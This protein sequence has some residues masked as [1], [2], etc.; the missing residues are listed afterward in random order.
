ML[1]TGIIRNVAALAGLAIAMLVNGQE[2]RAANL[3]PVFGAGAATCGY[4]LQH[5]AKDDV[6]HVILGAWIEGY[7]TANN[8]QRAD[9]HAPF[10]GLSTDES[11]RGAWV[12]QYC[13]AHPL[14]SLCSA[15]WALVQEFEKI[16][17]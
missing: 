7:L 15:T 17:R 16:G 6:N 13:Q 2:V 10:V 11:G 3:T 8:R 5:T 9:S 1:R 4:W 12:S 14:D